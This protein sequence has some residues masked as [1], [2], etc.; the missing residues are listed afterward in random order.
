MKLVPLFGRDG[1]ARTPSLRFWRPTL[2]QLSYIPRNWNHEIGGA[3]GNRTPVESACNRTHG[4]S[5]TAPIAEVEWSRGM[6]SNPCCPDWAPCQ[7]AA[8]KLVAGARIRTLRTPGYEP[9]G[10]AA[11]PPRTTVL[12]SQRSLVRCLIESVCP[13]GPL[14]RALAAGLA[15]RCCCTRKLERDTRIELATYTLATCRSTA[16]LIPREKMAGAPRIERG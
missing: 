16:E 9:G 5:D 3:G 12:H 7:T 13:R 10:I 4:L 1:G 11:R 2:N 15:G 8:M 14:S 6:G